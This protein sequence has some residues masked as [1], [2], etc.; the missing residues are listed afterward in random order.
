MYS[1]KELI[2][3][4]NKCLPLNKSDIILLK[5]FYE[6]ICLSAD[7]LGPEFSLFNIELNN[8][9]EQFQRIIADEQFF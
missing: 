6:D 3:R 9:K 7:C 1:V 8:R 4:H 2:E 5:E